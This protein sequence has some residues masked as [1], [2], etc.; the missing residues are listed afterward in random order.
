MVHFTYSEPRSTNEGPF[1]VSPRKHYILFSTKNPPAVQRIPWPEIEEEDGAVDGEPKT[2]FG[3]Y[4]TW[5]FNDHDFEF[6]VDSDGV[7][8]RLN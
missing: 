6:F 3:S 2:Q 4:E 7:F 8:S 5:I 1:S